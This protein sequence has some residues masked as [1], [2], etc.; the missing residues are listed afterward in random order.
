MAIYRTIQ[1]SFWTDEKVLD[2]FTPEDKYFYLYLFTNP[3]TNL[4]GCYQLGWTQTTNQTG[5][6]K[7]SLM[8]LID[9]FVNV[10]KVLD[11]STDT[12]EIL[13]L[14][15]HKYNWTVS[16]RFLISLR[17]EIELIKNTKYQKH[18]MALFNT[19][20]TNALNNK[21][22]KEKELEL[23]KKI[24]FFDLGQKT[25]IGYAYPMDTTVT[26][27][28]TVTDNISNSIK[29]IIDYL[30]SICNTNYK[31]KTAN[32]KK[33]IQ[34]RLNEGYT[35]DD[36]KTVIDKKAKEWLGTDMERYLR[37]DTLFGTKFEGYL[38]QK[39]VKPNGNGKERDLLQELWEV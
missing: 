17:K 7:E 11:Y 6:T 28:D 20:L 10:H 33:H 19:Y 39:I 26:V 4:C 25:N 18:L 12:K 38:N 34:A 36:F 21:D 29:E 16:A 2:D 22:V 1:L 30:N 32:T 23:L 27:T 24:E 3:Q 31:S 5:Y 14:N 35:V 13:L 8:R 15:W 9:R 37:P